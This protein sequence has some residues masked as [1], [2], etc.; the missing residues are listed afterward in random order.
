M[1][2][3]KYLYLTTIRLKRN[4]KLNA[5]IFI[6][7]FLFVFCG[8]VLNF[9]QTNLVKTKNEIEKN[10]SKIVIYNC[11]EDVV[12]QYA[13]EYKFKISEIF[14][15]NDKCTITAETVRDAH[16]ILSFL[17]TMDYSGVFYDEENGSPAVFNNHII[18]FIN[19]TNKLFIISLSLAI[20]FIF[21]K[22]LFNEKSEYNAYMVFGY[23]CREIRI[24]L[25]LDMLAIT[26]TPSLTGFGLAI[27]LSNTISKKILEK[28][29]MYDNIPYKENL[30]YIV[31]LLFFDV[32]IF[33]ITAVYFTK[34]AKSPDFERRL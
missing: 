11:N 5:S 25:M 16:Q 27:P 23:K 15:E 3:K 9:V 32:G 12:L 19:I 6:L 21:L 10:A 29:L 18:N 28:Y 24:L 26:L 14:C 33:I 34:T 22:K 20:F 7:V 4:I 2:S 17:N 13:E 1:N 31:L 8:N 30:L